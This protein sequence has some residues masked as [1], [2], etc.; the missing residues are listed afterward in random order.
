MAEDSFMTAVIKCFEA[1]EGRNTIIQKQ[2]Q[3]LATLYVEVCTMS[4]I[5]GPLGGIEMLSTVVKLN[6]LVSHSE[7]KEPMWYLGML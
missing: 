1:L 5:T 4:E 2:S 3:A 6:I 7:G